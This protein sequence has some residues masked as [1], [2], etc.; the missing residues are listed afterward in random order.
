MYSIRL[1]LL[2]TNHLTGVLAPYITHWTICLSKEGQTHSSG[3]KAL[4][5]EFELP[6]QV[7]ASKLLRCIVLCLAATARRGWGMHQMDQMAVPSLVSI[8]ASCSLSYRFL[9]WLTGLT[10]G[11]EFA[12]CVSLHFI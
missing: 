8:A 2:A 1:T 3:V 9:P 11:F 10:T 12:G 7:P 5:G 6:L 4:H